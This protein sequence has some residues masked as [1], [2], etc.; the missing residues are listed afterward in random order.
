M[1]FTQARLRPAEL[2]SRLAAHHIHCW[3]G[4]SYALALSQALGLEPDGVL[5]LGMLHYN[6]TAEVDRVLD[7]LRTLLR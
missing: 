7:V 1:S 5:R 4:N 2:A 6:T 3:A